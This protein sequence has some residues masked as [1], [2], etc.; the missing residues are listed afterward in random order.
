MT[1]DQ[2][3]ISST[4]GYGSGMTRPRTGMIRGQATA[5]PVVLLLLA[6]LAL[7]VGCG[8]P[9]AEVEPPADTTDS[10]GATAAA[11]PG[12]APT[13]DEDASFTFDDIG[14]YPSGIE[15]EIAGSSARKVTAE[16]TGADS[17]N[18]EIVVVSVLIR[19]DSDVDID[20]TR[21]Q[22]TASY[23]ATDTEAAVVTDPTG[24]LT[25]AFLGSITAGGE[26]TA[27]YAFAIPFRQLSRVNVTVDL[28][29]DVHE[30]VSFT[31]SVVRE[32]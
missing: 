16:M 9:A 8:R 13:V 12:T 14:S 19:N 3:P 20:G 5:G 29:D 15:V 2:P 4:S 17:T 11:S 1:A 27:G 24:A 28:A 32:Q 10:T 26:E 7:L 18:G 6:A 21:V 22:V 31:D 25:N 23:G 30:P